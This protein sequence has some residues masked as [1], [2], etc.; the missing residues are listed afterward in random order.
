MQLYNKQDWNKFG[1]TLVVLYRSIAGRFCSQQVWSFVKE[2]YYSHLPLCF[3]TCTCKNESIIF[4]NVPLFLYSN[5]NIIPQKM[6]FTPSGLTFVGWYHWSLLPV[7]K[8]NLLSLSTNVVI[9][10]VLRIKCLSWWN[11]WFCHGV[12]KARVKC[13]KMCNLI[14][15]LFHF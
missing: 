9:I 13:V 5:E 14:K 2:L 8:W 7:V 3:F 10:I 12:T 6:F 15:M 4:S 1:C 11:R